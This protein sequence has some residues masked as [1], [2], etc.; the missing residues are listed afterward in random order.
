MRQQQQQ[1]A[2]GCGF[3]PAALRFTSLANRAME[4]KR[5]TQFGMR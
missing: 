4:K 1:Q 3:L 2:A 5:E